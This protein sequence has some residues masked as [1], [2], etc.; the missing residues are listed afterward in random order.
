MQYVVADLG[1]EGEGAA[2][3]RCAVHDGVGRELGHDEHRSVG[4]RAVP[5]RARTPENRM[6]A[7]ARDGAS[8]SS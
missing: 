2:V 1:A 5:E 3:A 7:P 4:H 6:S 8:Y